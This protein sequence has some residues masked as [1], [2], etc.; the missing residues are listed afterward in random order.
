MDA[1]TSNLRN[2]L[3]TISM[4]VPKCAC[5]AAPAN[6]GPATPVCIYTKMSSYGPQ[7]F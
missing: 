4:H 7:K 5:M 3:N 6:L 1:L 2:K